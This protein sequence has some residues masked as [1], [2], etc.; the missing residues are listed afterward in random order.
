MKKISF[1]IVF[2]VLGI[3]SL[4]AQS[5]ENLS[6]LS[7]VEYEVELSDVWG[8]T[9]KNGQEYA[10]V[11]LENGTSILDLS[12]PR[13]PVEVARIP[14]GVS[15]WKDIKTYENRAFIVGEYPQG[16]QI[17]DLTNLPNVLDSTAYQYWET[18][19]PQVGKIGSCHNIYIE[20]ATGIAYLSG[21]SNGLGV[22][23]VDIKPET[24]VYL[25]KTNTG[26]SHDVFV[27]NDTIYSSDMD[28]GVFSIIDATSKNAPTVIANQNTP[29]RFTHNTW[30]SDDGKT[31]FTTDEVMDAPVAAYDISDL[32]DIQLL[33]RFYPKGTKGTGLVPHNVHVKNDFLITSYY[34][35]GVIITD[36]S[37]PNSLVQ[38]GS[39]DTYNG[40][41][42][43]L[44]GTWGAFPFFKSD[45]ILASDIE[46]GL[47]VLQ[48]KYVRATFLNGI[49]TDS[50]SGAAIPN[51]Q[52]EGVNRGVTVLESKTGLDGTYEIGSTQTGNI[53]V[54]FSKP[55]YQSKTISLRFESGQLFNELII[56][57][58]IDSTDNTTSLEALH[59]LSNF[60]AFPNPFY[61][62]STVK[63][64]LDEV[65]KQATLSIIDVTGKVM[66]KHSLQSNKGQVVVG[67]NLP[68]GIYFGQI[69]VGTKS[70]E[71]LK[72]IKH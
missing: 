62:Q 36:A 54:T 51:V 19:N 70:S 48:P 47:F 46:N 68:K 40:P 44:F 27:R 71:L 39:Y 35:E 28:E 25:G 6:L 22:I 67:K 63:Y 1:G 31:L 16:M 34:A 14:G 32:T 61:H 29:S 52:I 8:Y 24:P 12:E 55:A 66:Q 50:V 7:K 2:T 10:L 13:E 56:L 64:E 45:I 38:V 49:V 53:K 18:I 60:N 26:Y 33:D 72:L 5:N 65:V 59:L 3:F 21:C 11:G 30:L 69:S 57:A 37:R 17:I 42:S 43:S 4:T 41:N 15:F 9:D 58:P 23:I 20:E